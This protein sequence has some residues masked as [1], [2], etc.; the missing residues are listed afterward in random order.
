MKIKIGKVL[1]G[2]F[3]VVALCSVFATPILADNRL[4]VPL[5]GQR[6]YGDATIGDTDS[7]IADYGCAI[8]SIAMILGYYGMDKE[9]SNPLEVNEW[10]TNHGG[11]IGDEV[12]P[13]GWNE[14]IREMS[15]DKVQWQERINRN[16][17]S[18][19]RLNQEIDSGY[20]VITEVRLFSSKHFIVI[21]GRVGKR[22]YI[23]DPY[24][25]DRTILTECGRYGT[26]PLGAIYSLRIYR[27]PIP[28]R[29]HSTG[30]L[31][32]SSSDKT[33]QI[34]N[35]QK[36]FIPT[37]NVFDSWNFKEEQI[38]TLSNKE[39]DQYPEGEQI[40]FREGTLI[41]NQTSGERYVI[42]H[43]KKRLITS[44]E[45]FNQLGY[46]E[47]NVIWLTDQSELDLCSDG[48]PI[49]WQDGTVWHT[50][51]TL[52]KSSAG[53]TYKVIGGQQK[54]RIFSGNV[55]D[56]RFGD[57]NRIINLSELANCDTYQYTTVPPAIDFQDGA[58][59][60]HGFNLYV[61]AEKEKRY[62]ENEEIRDIFGYTWEPIPVSDDEFNLHQQGEDITK[63]NSVKYPYI[64]V[65]GDY[66][67]IQEA[68]DNA[69]EGDKIIVREGTY[70][71]NVKVNKRLTLIG[72]GEVIVQ[73]ENPDNHVFEISP[74]ANVSGFIAAGATGTKKA[75][76][77]LCGCILNNI[78]LSHNTA[79]GNYYGILLGNTH[80]SYIAG[81]IVSDNNYGIYSRGSR[82]NIILE[83]IIK[84]NVGIGI[85]LDYS[86]SNDIIGN[87]INN[88]G[89][90]GIIF[91]WI[92]SNN[93][94]ASNIIKNNSENGINIKSLATG[95]HFI[96]NQ[97]IDN[98]YNF[99]ASNFDNDID[100]TN[101]VNG[102]PI[103]FI[104][105]ASG[106]TID[107]STNAGVV[108]CIECDDVTI[109]DLELEN[110]EPSIYF[111]K[112]DNSNIEN[113]KI[114]IGPTGIRLY[115]SN[116]NNIKGNTFRDT[117][118][119]IHLKY[120]DNNI[121]Y[122]NDL[123][124]NENNFYYR[125]S[126]NTWNSP[127]QITYTYQTNTHTNHLG[128][129]WDDYT[130][131]DSN[132]DGI[133][134]NPYR[135]DSD[136]DNYPLT[137]PFENYLPQESSTLS[138]K[139]FCPVN[140]SVTDPDSR[141]INPET[142]EILGASY[143]ETDINGDGDPDDIIS[144]SDR[145]IGDYLITVT[146]E[147]DAEPTDTYTLEVTVG[148]T[149]IVLVENVPISDIPDQPYVIESTEEGIE[150]KTPP[151]E[152]IPE[153]ATIAIPVAAILGLV[154]L[155]RRRRHKK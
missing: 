128:N 96:E 31:I 58:L 50:R 116:N 84:D 76:F 93:R 153:F 26:D 92:S 57:W 69:L 48:E 142:N 129:Y 106:I 78:N 32:N 86:S 149:T 94:I 37:D 123:I 30:T 109:K 55:F 46:K 52:I 121:I 131:I 20:P 112:T 40:V 95:N 144:I 1:I 104:K 59:I 111:Y 60:L 148:D 21:T 47:E 29:I 36:R 145:K 139:A 98:R 14:S 6:W 9:D 143:T 19:D 2:I 24:Y 126:T 25:G 45:V 124:G 117:Q 152:P 137:Q 114:S 119:A 100:T 83:N 113:V 56:S 135:I 18:L 146:P 3:L 141:T 103:Y 4:N 11:Y 10:L 44:N 134:D 132:N 51:G 130:D 67:T 110:N 33:Y 35:N 39:I 75:G 85:S 150:D 12:R 74:N 8:T 125:D 101:L 77:M 42:E 68:I 54:R 89:G 107:S 154:F 17:V 13:Y 120:S 79:S 65:P 71:E 22:Y 72:E 7:T 133:W 16:E 122:L 136:A 28:T 80:N 70:N 91:K 127:N 15:R 151:A 38:I 27:G 87:T 62:I 82:G 49:V 90:G 88:N 41:G 34:Q 102:K 97:M 118:Y 53:N 66:P 147:L 64:C 115:Y 108:Y 138:I 5:Y 23:N 43:N 63:K 140:L 155:F 99:V 61:I 73:A 81:N 105:Y